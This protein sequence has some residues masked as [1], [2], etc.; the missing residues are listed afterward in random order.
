MASIST[1]RTNL[2]ARL[3]TITGLRTAAT[4][5]DSPNP[6]IAVVTPVSVTFD[7]AFQRGMN[8]YS[9]NVMVIVGRVDERTAQNN[10]DAYVSS[11]GT[12]SIKL[13]IEGDKSLAGA[14]FDTRVVEMRT[15][16]AVSIGEVTY[17]A[18]EFTVLCY[19]D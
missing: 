19:A 7:T 6:P 4:M 14:V 5:P 16:G 2:A 12:S 11:T 13:A 17:I 1:I 8:T 15:Y 10:L 3:A 9:F 18:A